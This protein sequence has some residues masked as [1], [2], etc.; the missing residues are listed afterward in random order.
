MQTGKMS[1]GHSLIPKSEYAHNVHIAQAND[2]PMD[3]W[4]GVSRYNA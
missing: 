3:E 4:C 2:D 1:Q